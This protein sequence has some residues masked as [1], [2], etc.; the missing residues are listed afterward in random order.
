MML[1]DIGYGALLL[2]F[3]LLLRRRIASG[4]LHDLANIL[5]LG[6]GWTIVFGFLF[7]ELFG[8]LGEEI[9]LHPILFDRAESDHLVELLALTLSIGAAHILLSLLLGLWEGI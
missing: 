4:M 2:A 3:T 6:A 1:G 8:T 9:G 5:A 7:G